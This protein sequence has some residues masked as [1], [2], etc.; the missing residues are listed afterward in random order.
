MVCVC[1]VWFQNRRAKCRKHES[2]MQKGEFYVRI[3]KYKLHNNEHVGVGR[4]INS[5]F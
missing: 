4:E 5:E 3:Y 2:Q 1:Q